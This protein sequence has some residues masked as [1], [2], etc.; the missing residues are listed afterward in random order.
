VRGCILTPQGDPVGWE[1][2]KYFDP[3]EL[4]KLNYTGMTTTGEMSGTQ[5]RRSLNCL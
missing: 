3:K 2:T 1:Q 4:I 5:V